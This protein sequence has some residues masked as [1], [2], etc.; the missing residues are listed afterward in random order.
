M[1]FYPLR[2]AYLKAVSYEGTDKIDKKE[3]VS[4]F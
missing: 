4:V 2:I 1:E 3:S